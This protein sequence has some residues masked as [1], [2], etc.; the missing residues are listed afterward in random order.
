MFWGLAAKKFPSREGRAMPRV[1]QVSFAAWRQSW[2]QGRMWPMQEMSMV[3]RGYGNAA[4]ETLEQLGLQHSMT[5]AGYVPAWSC[6]PAHVA[7]RASRVWSSKIWPHFKNIDLPFN[8]YG[9]NQKLFSASADQTFTWNFNSWM[10][11]WSPTPAL[12][13]QQDPFF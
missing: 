3:Q 10:E 7:I 2:V 8:L 11:L 1:V 4:L 9:G 6:S 13:D 12:E 5:L